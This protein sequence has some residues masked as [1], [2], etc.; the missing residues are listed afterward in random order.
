MQ[1]R[2]SRFVALSLLLTA[3]AYAEEPHKCNASARECEQQIRQ[4]MTGRRYLGVLVEEVNPGLVI[5][6]VAPDSPAARA[7]L[8]PGDRLMAVN[9][10]K[11]D[12][13]TIADFKQVISDA[14]NTG[15]LWIILQ[16]HGS[17]KRIEARLEPLT[18]AQVDKIVAQHL[19]EAHPTEAHA[20]SRQ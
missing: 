20:P 2:F 16:R 7:D 15:R 6:S 5:K 13:A 19:M 18:E 3:A 12:K 11:T 9:G 14:K 8:K 17:L 1:F 4:M 10:H